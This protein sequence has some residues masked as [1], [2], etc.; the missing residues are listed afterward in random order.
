MVVEAAREPVLSPESVI[1]QPV[2]LFVFTFSVVVAKTAVPGESAGK[3]FVLTTKVSDADPA[4]VPQI[5]VVYA[6]PSPTWALVVPDIDP[7][8]VS[9]PVQLVD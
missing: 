2:E 8:V 3:S 4:A 6:V 5:F 7:S 1:F 9:K